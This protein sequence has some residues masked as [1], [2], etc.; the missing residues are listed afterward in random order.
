[1]H[2]LPR[3]QDT[4]TNNDCVKEIK[5]DKKSYRTD[6]RFIS[7]ITVFLSPGTSIL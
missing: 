2:R 3:Q 6:I 1:M 7:L 5:L 4:V